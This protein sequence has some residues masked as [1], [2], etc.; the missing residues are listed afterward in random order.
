MN[1]GISVIIPTYN[2]EKFIGEAIRSVLQQDYEGNIEIIV[3]DDGSTDKTIDIVKSFGDKVIVILKPDN[4]NKQGV[5]ANR[6][7]GIRLASQPFVSF[8]DSDDF[9]LPGHLKNIASSLNRNADFG[10]AFCRIL[11][12]KEINGKELFRLWT[13]AS[14]FKNDIKNIAVS[15]SRVVHTNAFIFRRHVFDT[16][17]FFDEA[18]SNGEDTDL[19]MRISENYKGTF[20]DHIGAVYRIDHNMSQLTKNATGHLKNCYAEIHEKAIKRYYQI[21][22]KDNNRLFKLKQW[23]LICYYR[24]ERWK[25]YTRYFILIF[26][27][28][29]TFIKRTPLFF[30]E[31]LERQKSNKWKELKY[32]LH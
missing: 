4:C 27:F 21:G 10:F 1:S 9:Y 28:P 29:I 31:C 7:R 13:H 12:M 2:R 14:I 26:E 24:P 15:R 25:Y 16:V 22:L 3:S 11:E 30:S 17:G 23:L 20:S 18:Y 32:F 5:A 19:W 6:N 8:L